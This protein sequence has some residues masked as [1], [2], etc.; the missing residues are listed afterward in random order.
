MPPA[1]SLPTGRPSCGT[2]LRQGKLGGS[3][4]TWVE[5]GRPFRRTMF[6]RIF[7]PSKRF[8]RGE[9]P[10]W[11]AKGAACHSCGLVMVPTMRNKRGDKWMR[12]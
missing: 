12:W 5:E 4:F 6:S 2:E 10:F 11:S 9:W 1:P 8:G 7:A 3:W